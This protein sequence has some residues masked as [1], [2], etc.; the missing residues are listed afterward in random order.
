MKVTLIRHTKVEVP[1]GTCYGWSDIPV[2]DTF[3]EE[4]AITKEK[5][6][7]QLV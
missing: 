5:L 4:A 7:Q 1:K 6:D 3:M 2:A